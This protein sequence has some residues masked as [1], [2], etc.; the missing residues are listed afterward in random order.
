[1]K[2]FFIILG[3][4]CFYAN[5]SAQYD[6]QFYHPQ[7]D[8]IPCQ[9]SVYE[10]I[11]FHPQT[12]T[13]HSLLCKPQGRPKATL[14]YIHGNSGNISY[15]SG[16]INTFVKAG[17]QVFIA[18]FRGYGKS[19]GHPT[20]LNIA[21]DGQLILD[22]LLKRPDVKNTTFILY[23]AS[24]GTQLA[25]K[26]A[27]DNQDK[28]DALLLEGGMSSFADIA[29]QSIPEE[30]R[31]MARPFLIFPYSAKTDIT[32][33]NRL[34]KLIIHSPDDETVP[35]RQAQ[36]VFQKA[37]EP[38]YF[39]Q[40]RGKHLEA[41]KIEPDT[42]IKAIQNLIQLKKEN[43]ENHSKFITQ[44]TSKVILPATVHLYCHDAVSPVYQLYL[45]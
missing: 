7:K 18:D 2:F 41:I 1:M 12:D 9:L 21:A 27:K 17:F 40:S 16:L 6:N 19:S 37:P 33:I 42:I 14:F 4:M 36:E 10:E 44:I 13:L 39:L 20:H 43:D 29:L 38:K 15:Y 25:T 31:E 26:L 5:A 8:W 45:L 34:P 32:A 28:I 11:Y 24:N 35:Y 23:G 3:I 22:S 30:Q